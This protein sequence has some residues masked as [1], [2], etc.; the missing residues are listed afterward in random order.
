MFRSV[1]LLSGS[2]ELAVVLPV[3]SSTELNTHFITVLTSDGRYHYAPFA[4]DCGNLRD[5]NTDFSDGGDPFSPLQQLMAVFPPDSA[6]LLPEPLAEAMTNRSS[7]IADFYPLDFE[8]DRNGFKYDWQGVALLPFVDEA[9]LNLV[10]E[11]RVKRLSRKRRAKNTFGCDRIFARVQ[12]DLQALGD[13]I[14]ETIS[15]TPVEV[16][17][18]IAL[19]TAAG[20]N[21][22]VTAKLKAAI[23]SLC[24]GTL[25]S[26]KLN[27][28]SGHVRLDFVGSP[29]EVFLFGSSFKA[30]GLPRVTPSVACA[31]YRNPA[32]LL[33][34]EHT[35]KELAGTSWPP[36]R[37]GRRD[38]D[39][40]KHLR[41]AKFAV[42]GAPEIADEVV[43]L[44]KRVK[45]KEYLTQPAKNKTKWRSSGNLPFASSKR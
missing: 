45:P 41:G 12:G 21:A 1:V 27:G 26:A 14:L 29:S 37:L 17:N 19:R 25:D 43:P 20:R 24:W 4:S 33:S 5:V 31:Y 36:P 10:Y 15:C 8:T 2:S 28:V 3:S 34:V 16:E 7:E 32:H 18:L 35:V 9:R 38:R 44:Q 39:K 13:H 40:G 42:S 22:S 6:H 23:R 11:E 30:K